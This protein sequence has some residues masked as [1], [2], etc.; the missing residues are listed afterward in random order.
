M[1]EITIEDIFGPDSPPKQ[2]KIS[3]IV[4]P[5]PS[6]KTILKRPLG[7]PL[8]F[9]QNPLKP[10]KECLGERIHN[11]A[12]ATLKDTSR[13]FHKL[14]K[15]Q[16]DIC[17]ISR[18]EHA[19]NIKIEQILA[20]NTVLTLENQILTRKISEIQE[21]QSK[22]LKILESLQ[23]PQSRSYFSQIKPNF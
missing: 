19:K 18:K 4:E 7:K 22:M 13:I 3:K 14:E 20:A 9:T 15:V 2:P 8:K 6:F 10:A 17:T 11:V 23:N 5:K 12:F 1:A 16:A 21:S